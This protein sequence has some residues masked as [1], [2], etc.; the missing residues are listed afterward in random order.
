MRTVAIRTLALL[1]AGV[2][3]AACGIEPD[4]SPRD[5]P[6]EDRIGVMVVTGEE[7]TGTSRI[8]LLAP[9]DQDEPSRLRAVSRDVPNDPQ[10]LLSSLFAGP[11]ADEQDQRL[12]TAIPRDIELLGTRSVGQVLTID[13]TDVFG[14]LT[15]EALRLATA[16]IVVTADEVEGVDAVRIRIDGEPRAWPV[17]NG[18]LTDAALTVYDYP[19]LV[20]SSQPALPAIPSAEAPA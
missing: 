1:I 15:P 8:H 11:N 18:E 4:S 2:L 17:G 14:E 20:E 5:V 19:G 6:D 3:A 9:S 7:A 12:G 16:Q 13:V 10:A